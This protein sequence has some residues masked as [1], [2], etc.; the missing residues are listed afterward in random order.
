MALV[1]KTY[2]ITSH[3][4]EWVKARVASGKYA[5]DSEYLRELIRRDEEETEKLEALRAALIEG[6][7]SGISSRSPDDI[8]QAVL[9]RKGLDG[10]V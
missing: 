10:K 1:K 6:E 2:S 5:T 7:Q 9:A 8:L 4:D 3:H